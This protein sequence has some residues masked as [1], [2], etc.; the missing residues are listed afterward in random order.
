MFVQ[1]MGLAKRM[2]LLLQKLED[3]VRERIPFYMSITV[4][5]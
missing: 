2:H 1:A 4:N 3:A 5:S